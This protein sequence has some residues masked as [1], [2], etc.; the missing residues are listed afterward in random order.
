MILVEMND[1]KGAAEVGEMLEQLV[2]RLNPKTKVIL[3]ACGQATF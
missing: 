3:L 2:M 1:L